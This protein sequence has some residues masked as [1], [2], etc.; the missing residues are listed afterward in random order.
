MSADSRKSF[1]MTDEALTCTAIGREFA[2]PGAVNHSADEY[3]HTGFVHTNTIENFF[4]ILKRGAYGVY[5]HVSEAHLSRYL[6]EF[7][8]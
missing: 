7:D 2:G 1:L 6:I 8:R 5:H 4:S 3:I